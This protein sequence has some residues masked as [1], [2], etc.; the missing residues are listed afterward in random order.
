MRAKTTPTG[1]SKYSTISEGELANH[2]LGFGSLSS[3]PAWAL[4]EPAGIAIDKQIA[5]SAISHVLLTR[6][7][8]PKY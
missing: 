4:A 7:F 1:S 3:S 5:M 8:T 2:E 6:M